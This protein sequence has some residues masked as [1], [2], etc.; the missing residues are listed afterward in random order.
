MQY[1]SLG[2]ALQCTSLGSALQ[3]K[4]HYTTHLQFQLVELYNPP[5]IS[6]SLYYTTHLQFQLVVLYNPPAI[7][8]RCIIQPTCK[9][10][11]LYYTTHLQFQLVVL[12]NPP[13][14]LAWPATSLAAAPARGW[15]PARHCGHQ[16]RKTAR[17]VAHPPGTAFPSAP[18]PHSLHTHTRVQCVRCEYVH[19]HTA[20]HA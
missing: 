4:L 3:Y 9:F 16:R 5:A 10:S 6:S 14:F 18:H 13:A 12:Y 1:T 2:S 8:A 15:R 17:S 20:A 7:S 19:A 11:S